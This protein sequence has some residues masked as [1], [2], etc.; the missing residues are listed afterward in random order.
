MR[1]FLEARHWHSFHLE[2]MKAIVMKTVGG[3]PKLGVREYSSL[4]KINKIIKSN[5]SE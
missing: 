3:V 5:A 4:L 2:K 1:C